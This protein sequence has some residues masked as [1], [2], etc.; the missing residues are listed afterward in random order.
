MGSLSRLRR[1]VES[2]AP[3][4]GAWAKDSIELLQAEGLAAIHWYDPDVSAGSRAEDIVESCAHFG[5]PPP[6]A[7]NAAV[8]T[9]AHAALR[10]LRSAL[11]A[12]GPSPRWATHYDPSSPR[13]TFAR[14]R[15]RLSPG[16]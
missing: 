2:L 14:L 9:E 6:S 15:D 8:I 11:R 5:V 12:E 4:G 3:R 1:D 13:G 7:M 16:V 10:A